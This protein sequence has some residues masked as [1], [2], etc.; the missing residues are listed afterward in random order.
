MGI[1]R[2]KWQEEKFNKM[3]T[4]KSGSFGA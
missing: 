4:V 3:A 2:G 1:K